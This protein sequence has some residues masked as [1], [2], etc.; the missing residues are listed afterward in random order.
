[1]DR[2]VVIIC[3]HLLNKPSCAKCAFKTEPVDC[4]DSGWQ[5]FCGEINHSEEDAKIVSMEELKQMIPS[6]IPILGSPAP[7]TFVFDGS[8][9]VNREAEG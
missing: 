4:S 6:A 3:K 1:M 2:K 5:F 9:W 7:S 8:S